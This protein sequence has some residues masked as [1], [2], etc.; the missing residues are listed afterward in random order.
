M[1]TLINKRK[2]PPRGFPY[3]CPVCGFKVKNPLSPWS[4]VVREIRIHRRNNPTHNLTTDT[5]TIER[6]LELYTC[7]RLDNSSSYCHD[8]E[9]I[10]YEQS[11]TKPAR[12]GCSTCGRGKKST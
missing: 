1:I 10:I 2:S 9:A 7:Q 8:I 3:R 5:A 4:E 6:E 11:Q 12:K